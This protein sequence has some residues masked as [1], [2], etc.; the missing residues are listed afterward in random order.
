[1][2]SGDLDLPKVGS[3]GVGDLKR[4][5]R[6]LRDARS[7]AGRLARSARP[8]LAAALLLGAASATHAQTF[9]CARETVGQL[10]IQAG[11]RCQ[12]VQVPAGSI[13]GTA[14]GYAWDCGVLRGRLNQ[15][16]PAAP[17]TYQGP[18]IDAVIIESD[19]LPRPHD[20]RRS[21]QP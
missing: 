20:P 14:A 5:C 2:R 17:E 6:G 4:G 8:W 16:V 1:M 21:R 7:V 11:A 13:T 19:P 18:P 9:A 10:S 3:V 12:C 15:L